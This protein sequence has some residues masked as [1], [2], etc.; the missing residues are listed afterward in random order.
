M[1][2]I[3]LRSYRALI[4]GLVIASLGG[5][6]DSF[7]GSNVQFDFSTA[8]PL[9]GGTDPDGSTPPENTYFAFYAFD[10][11]YATD[12]DG[13]ILR[14]FD[15]DPIILTTAAFDVQR[16]E[17]RPAI[18]RDSPCFIELEDATYPGLHVTQIVTKVKDETG[19]NDPT[20]PGN[21]A[22]EGDISDV[23]NAQR[24]FDLLQRYEE[25]L[26]AM[27]SFSTFRYPAAAAGCGVSGDE[28]PAPTCIEEADNA[29]RLRACRAL[30]ADNPDY[31][32]GSDKVFTL[33]LNGTLFGMV[34]GTNPSNGLSPVGGAT[35][36]VDEDL[37]SADA[38]SIN[39]QY[40]D[41]DGDGQPDYPTDFMT[42]HQAS[43]TGYTWLSGLP[44]ERARGVTNVHLENPLDTTIF[45]DVAI[46]ADLKHD[47]VQF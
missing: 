44:E 47:D 1:P 22:S 5:C 36:F 3:A 37:V 39:W 23:L 41:L 32:E 25:G 17:L 9:P 11:E 26:K 45:A 30:W 4:A 20:D 14:D 24:R 46:F 6:V 8:T 33:P 19:I 38:F 31:Y 35:M 10:H 7:T 29:Q 42:T 43:E 16:F 21:G 2:S 28:I 27:V 34:E 12:E 40:K 15:G 18:D 13:T